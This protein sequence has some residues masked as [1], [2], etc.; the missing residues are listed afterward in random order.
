M[1]NASAETFLLLEQ[2]DTV[3]QVTNVTKSTQI[4]RTTPCF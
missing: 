4:Q 3:Q 2:Y 1:K